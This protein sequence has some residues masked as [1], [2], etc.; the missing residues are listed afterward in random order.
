MATKEEIKRYL[1]TESLTQ[2]RPDRWYQGGISLS[3]GLFS[4][5][6]SSQGDCRGVWKL[7]NLVDRDIKG[8]DILDVG[9]NSGF[10]AMRCKETGADRVVGLDPSDWIE[11]ARKF[12]EWKGLDIEWQKVDFYQFDWSRRFDTILVLQVLYH[13]KDSKKALE[14][15]AN[16]CKETLIF[17]T[18]VA[19]E[20]ADREGFA[21]NYVGS[22][23]PTL[24]EFRNDLEELGFRITYIGCRN[25]DLLLDVAEN[26][27]PIID[28]L[29]I[30]AVRK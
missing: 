11:S 6:L 22:Y 18:Q 1:A 30:K 12:S 26:R 21:K 16:S 23:F 9:T 8:K 19:S 20:Q 4:E 24:S 14:L 7:L 15:L 29:A 27:E 5:S 3:H 25:P 13:I 17:Y 10:Y 28:K 2:G